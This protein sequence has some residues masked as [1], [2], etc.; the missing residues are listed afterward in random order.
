MVCQRHDFLTQTGV[1]GIMC[2]FHCPGFNGTN[3]RFCRET[4]NVTN[5][6]FLGLLWTQTMLHLLAFVANQV[7]SPIRAYFGLFCPDFYS[8]IRDFTQILCRYLARILAA[9]TSV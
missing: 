1:L 8:D 9:G 3:T 6:R 7:L 5:T 4:D 2:F